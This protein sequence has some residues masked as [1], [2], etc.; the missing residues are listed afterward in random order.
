MAKVHLAD[1]E[2]G[3]HIFHC[4]GCGCSHSFWTNDPDKPRWSFNDDLEKPTVSPSH[5][6]KSGNANGD[7]ICH[8]FIRDGMIQYLNDC[9]HHLKGM[10]VKMVDW[11]N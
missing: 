8:S 2:T 9:T 11:E 3:W 6:V 10:T 7:T 1:P 5:R 4:P